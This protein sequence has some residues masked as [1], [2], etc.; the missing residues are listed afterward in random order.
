MDV[1]Y[2]NQVADLNTRRE[3]LMKTTQKDLKQALKYQNT[4]SNFEHE[5]FADYTKG[6]LWIYICSIKLNWM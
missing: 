3:L 2:E 6:S 4:Y 1:F 5:Y